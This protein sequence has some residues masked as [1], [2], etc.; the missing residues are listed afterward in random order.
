M[1]S[2][3]TLA[4]G[5][6]FVGLGLLALA[7]GVGPL[8]T[9]LRLRSGATT[10]AEAAGRATVE[11]VARVRD[12]PLT[13]PLS[14]DD[15]LAYEYGVA[16]GRDGDWEWVMGERDAVPFVVEDES[17]RALVSVADAT[18]DLTPESEFFEGSDELP[19]SYRERFDANA[20][21]DDSTAAVD[22]SVAGEHFATAAWIRVNRQ[23][24][25]PG[26]DVV[27]TGEVERTGEGPGCRL[28][29]TRLAHRAPPSAVRRLLR[30]GVVRSVAGLALVAVAVTAFGVLP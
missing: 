12:E 9:G 21:A 25:R 10:V 18:I 5:W 8:R 6:L 7:K 28:T 2:L 3:V 19:A 29:D 15:V 22:P 1:A 27:V 14:G 24:L 13:S 16:L 30:T 20:A 23:D 26:D 11:G 17:G 4:A